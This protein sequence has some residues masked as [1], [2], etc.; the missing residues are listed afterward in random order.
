MKENSSEGQF[1]TR[2]AGPGKAPQ[3]IPNP[4]WQDVPAQACAG[5]EFVAG[6]NH[7]ERLP[8]FIGGPD[9]F[10]QRLRSFRVAVIGAGSIGSNAIELLARMERGDGTETP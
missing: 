3:S 6:L 7:A 1:D 2:D 9:E 4:G 10:H 8:Q 5:A